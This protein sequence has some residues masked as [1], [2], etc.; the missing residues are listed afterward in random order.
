LVG[1]LAANDYLIRNGDANTTVG[2]LKVTGLRGWI[3]MTGD[4]GQSGSNRVATTDSFFGVNRSADV[5]RLAGWYYDGRGQP[6]PETFTGLAELLVREGASP[7]TIILNPVNSGLVKNQLGSKVIYETVE[8]F[9]NPQISFPAITF[10]GPA[11]PMKIISDRQCP[12]GM[13]YML[14]LD[15]WTLRSRGKAPR[16]ISYD[17]EGLE[18]IRIYNA[19]GIELRCGYYAQLGCSAPGFNGVFQLQ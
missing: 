14:T 16:I 5:T 2:T 15:T 10:E 4:N 3:P 18:A 19:D 6:I 11:G 9:N 17:M 8:A 1:G 7:D 13:G 12:I